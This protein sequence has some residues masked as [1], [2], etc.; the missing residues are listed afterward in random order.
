MS[1]ARTSFL[2]RMFSSRCFWQRCFMLRGKTSSFAAEREQHARIPV[3]HDD[4]G[5]LSPRA[6]ISCKNPI[7]VLVGY[8]DCR[9]QYEANPRPINAIACGDENRLFLLRSL[10][11]R[12]YVPKL[13]IQEFLVREIPFSKRLEISDRHRVTRLTTTST[14]PPLST[15]ANVASM[16]RVDIP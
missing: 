12:R 15:S 1:S 2:P 9:H 13:E 6:T 11:E 8:L 7:P 10:V 3:G 4:N 16:S 5:S 14:R